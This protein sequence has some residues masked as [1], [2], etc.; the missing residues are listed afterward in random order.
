MPYPS[1]ELCGA[2]AGLWV[3]GD[4]DPENWLENHIQLLKKQPVGQGRISNSFIPFTVHHH[5]LIIQEM[6]MLFTNHTQSH[7]VHGHL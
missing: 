2:W 7:T 5:T 6:D 3:A 4:P 1:L